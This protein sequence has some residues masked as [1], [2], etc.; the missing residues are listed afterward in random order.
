M[1]DGTRLI[2]IVA[3]IASNGLQYTPIGGSVQ[4]RLELVD[5]HLLPHPSS[6]RGSR[7]EK[8]S[9]RVSVQ[10]TGIGMSELEVRECSER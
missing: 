5:E 4:L 6:G 9:L 10:D 8:V 7:Q 1:C 3:N 2:Q